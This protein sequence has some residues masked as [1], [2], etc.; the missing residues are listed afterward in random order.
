MSSSEMQV[1]RAVLLAAGGMGKSVRFD[2]I[3]TSL[4]SIVKKFTKAYI[5]RRLNDLVENGFIIVDSIQTPRNYSITESNIAKA[6]ETKR[7]RKLAESLTSRQDFITKLE[8]LKSAKSQGLAIMLHKQLAGSSSI[9]ES[10]VIEGAENVRSTIIREFADGAQEGD[11]IRVLGHASTLAEGLGPGGVTELRLIQSGFRGVKV[12]GLLTP[13]GE[14]KL[15]LNLMTGH[16]ATMAE[17]FEQAAKTGNIQLRLTRKPINTYR[18]VSLNEDKMLLYLT[19]AKES[20]MAALV[21]REDNP[22]LIDDA[23][24]TFNELW[25]TGIDVLDLVKQ[26]L[27]KDKKS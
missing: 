1:F 6:L 2:E 9:G 24:S 4:E 15:D 18:I 16:L 26:M 21:H 8:R 17:P 3:A 22:G 25:E 27:Q 12:L 11:I 14:D 7:Q 10:G 5:Y 19:H 20:D 23:I 13:T